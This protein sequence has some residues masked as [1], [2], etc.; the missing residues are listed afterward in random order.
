MP[1]LTAS[2]R[3]ETLSQLL[4]RAALDY[5]P[6]AF[7]SS[8]SAEDMV[9]TDAILTGKLSLDD[10]DPNR[11]DFVMLEDEIAQT[12]QGVIADR[13]KEHLGRSDRG[14][15][16]L[17]KLWERELRNLAEGKPI[18]NWTYKAEMVPT[19]PHE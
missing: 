15:F 2:Q 13:G 16:L 17:R 1:Q 4:T 18:K 14:V 3:V 12:G 9:I 11:I 7:S 19:Y 6:A 8:L 10:V 5:G